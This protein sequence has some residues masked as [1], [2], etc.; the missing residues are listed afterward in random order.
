MR[1]RLIRAR[2]GYA[3]NSYL[4]ATPPLPVSVFRELNSEVLHNNY[5][6][7]EAETSHTFPV[8]GDFSRRLATKNTG[9]KLFLAPYIHLTFGHA[10]NR[11]L[12]RTSFRRERF[13]AVGTIR[14]ELRPFCASMLEIAKSVL[15]WGEDQSKTTDKLHV[16]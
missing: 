6:L 16:K 5:L 14:D 4:S 10:A 12:R 13:T 15:K 7:H 1:S 11:A 3:Y 9:G 2:K 8:S